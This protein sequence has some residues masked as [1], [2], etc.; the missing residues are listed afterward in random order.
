MVQVGILS[1]QLSARCC[2]AVSR[3]TE[4][5]WRNTDKSFKFSMACET[6]LGAFPF[7]VFCRNIVCRFLLNFASISRETSRVIGNVGTL[8]GTFFPSLDSFLWNLP[9]CRIRRRSC[10]SL[11]DM[12]KLRIQLTFSVTPTKD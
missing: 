10:C 3:A 1:Q 9:G 7:T 5:L 11:N 4:A 2:K 6:S 12:G 8:T